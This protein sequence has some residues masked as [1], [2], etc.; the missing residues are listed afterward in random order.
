MARTGNIVDNSI[1]QAALEGLELQ[2]KRIDDQISQV[3]AM[4][5]G[6]TKPAISVS[7]ATA[8]AS[9]KPKKRQLSKA[10]KERISA[11]QKKRWAAFREKEEAEKS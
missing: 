7:A 4:L 8:P 10:A 2:K 3:R 11:A 6:K 9:E 1:Y 5:A